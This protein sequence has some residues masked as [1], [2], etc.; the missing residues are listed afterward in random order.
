[1]DDVF[2]PA[3]GE[4][5]KSALARCSFLLISLSNKILFANSSSFLKFCNSLTECAFGLIRWGNDGKIRV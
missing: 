3:V 4:K 5:N 2:P 1:M